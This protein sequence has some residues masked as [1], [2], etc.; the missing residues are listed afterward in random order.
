MYD[1]FGVVGFGGPG[2]THSNLE[3]L[4]QI[5][6]KFPGRS[7]QFVRI[8]RDDLVLTG[9]NIRSCTL[10]S[11]EM[12]FTGVIYNLDEILGQHASFPTDDL[13]LLAFLLEHGESGVSRLN[14]R[15]AIV[16]LDRQEKSCKIF[17]D[18]MG[19]SQIFYHIGQD[20]LV[21]SS[22]L[23]YMF[24]H[25]LCPREI[26][27]VNALKRP[28]PFIVVNP[29]L[30]YN[31]WFKQIELLNEGSLLETSQSA[32][33]N[34]RT[35]WNP[36]A[37]A[38]SPGAQSDRSLEQYCD[39]YLALLDDAVRL[40]CA[41]PDSA[42]AMF[43]GGLDSSIIAALAQKHTEVQTYSF[44]TQATVQDGSTSMCQL[45]AADLHLPNTQVVVPY[46]TIIRDGVLWQQRIW[47][48]ESPFA[49]KDAISKTILHAAI[50]EINPG[51]RHIM[52]GTGSDQLNGGLVRWMS[53]DED[54]LEPDERWQNVIQNIST[55]YQKRFISHA[56]DAFWNSRDVL[57][58]QFIQSL[59]PG[60]VP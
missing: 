11:T 28:I 46:D 55:E 13:G 41:T 57:D 19:T 27:W 40:R 9:E 59:R 47:S 18:P 20:F 35:Y 36:W 10:G 14:G 43:S 42:F 6:L 52:T 31:A 45:L 38:S 24:C 54:D 60:W 26:D 3:A 7:S 30:N 23:K 49:H 17:N 21:F 39:E 16:L 22:E 15:F 32:G 12:F 2:H 44:A 29:E 4:D 25:P 1:I 5:A 50:S 51:A 53:M 33:V 8:I 58:A 34:V 37:A 56:Y 48:S